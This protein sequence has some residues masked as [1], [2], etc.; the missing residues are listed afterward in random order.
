MHCYTIRLRI[1]KP[2]SPKR[3]PVE[4]ARALA[5]KGVAPLVV[6]RVLL[7]TLEDQK[8]I[9]LETIQELG[10]ELQMI[11]NKGALM[12]LPTGVNKATGL[13]AAL[14]SLSLSGA[15]RLP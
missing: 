9:V 7:A 6:A 1:A 10:L 15:I 13:A 11:F 14:K 4:F 5:R 8:E 3:P 2:S 12:I